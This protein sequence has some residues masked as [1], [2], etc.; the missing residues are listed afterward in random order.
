MCVCVC[1]VCA[2]VCVC[3]CEVP[4]VYACLITVNLIRFT[5]PGA[6]SSH[7][8][9]K[10]IGRHSSALTHH[11]SEFRVHPPTFIVPC[12]EVILHHSQFTVPPSYC[13]LLTHWQAQCSPRFNHCS[14]HQ[15]HCWLPSAPLCTIGLHSKR[16]HLLSCMHGWPLPQLG[17]V[18]TTVKRPANCACTRATAAS[19]LLVCM[20]T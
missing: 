10:C 14:Q 4:H 16:D 2:C 18:R 20:Q 6:S 12:S 8:L 17:T 19:I 3:A 7:P 13:K 11:H 15:C 9:S 5:Q 1:S